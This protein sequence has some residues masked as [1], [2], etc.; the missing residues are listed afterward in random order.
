MTLAGTPRT[1]ATAMGGTRDVPVPD[2]LARDY[3]LLALRLDQHLPGTVDGYYGPAD[4]KAQVDLEPLVPPARLAD[5]AMAL[6]ER[7]GAEAPEPDRRHWL[8]LQLTA[9]EA[10]A[11]TSAGEAIPYLDLVT[12]CFA[13]TPRRR[14]PERFEAAAALLDG[15]LPGGGTLAA[16]LVAEDESWTVAPDRVPAVVEALVPRY[17]ARAAALFGLPE[18]EDVRVSMVRDQPWTGYNWYDGGYRSRVDINLDL[19]LRLPGLVGVTAH[20]TYPGHHLEHA[21]KEQTLVEGL[22]RLEASV[23][24]INTPE[25]LIS[26]G[27]ANVGK[28]I[29]V[30][31]AERAD[32]LV[33]LAPL[34]GAPLA[35]DG[36]R[37]REAAARQAALTEARGILDEARLNA[38]LMLH[39]DG[40]PREEVMDYLVEVGRLAP[41]TVEK[42][43]EFIEHPLWR[44]YVFVYAEGE[45]LLQ[46]WLDAVPE[47]DRPARF[48]RLL[49]EPLTPPA[50]EAEIATALPDPA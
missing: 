14:P 9:L 15:L 6:R 16:R 10:L 42:R 3:L 37:L 49:H 39:E 34:A 2:P 22:G 7:L 21:L 20:E 18:T 46:R 48:G 41:D 36:G 28:A 24:L 35:A 31:V 32:L 11:R 23:L 19:P 44:T 45:T 40:R 13:C 27:L 47:P 25:C 30:P 17:R 33:E 12:R 29:A 38:A 5:D 50:I 8:D 4:L 43:L 1:R 26:E